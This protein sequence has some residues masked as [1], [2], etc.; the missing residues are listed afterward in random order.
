MRVA[1]KIEYGGDLENGD[2]EAKITY[3]NKAM[4]MSKKTTV[5]LNV[6][7][8]KDNLKKVLRNFENPFR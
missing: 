8:K 2:L 6:I 5:I 3:K 4:G 1:N 7:S